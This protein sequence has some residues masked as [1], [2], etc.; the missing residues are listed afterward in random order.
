MAGGA[1]RLAKVAM[2][3]VD[4]RIQERRV[5]LAESAGQQ[6][7]AVIRSVLNRLELSDGR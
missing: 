6:R 7:A 4:V 5:R 2:T 3:C 1:D